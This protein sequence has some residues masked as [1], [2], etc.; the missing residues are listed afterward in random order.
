MSDV[1]SRRRR[2]TSTS[3]TIDTSNSSLLDE[4]WAHT[5]FGPTGIL[6]EVF[7]VIDKKPSGTHADIAAPGEQLQGGE[8]EIKRDKQGGNHTMTQIE[9]PGDVHGTLSY[10]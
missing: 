1:Q 8:G 2:P 10:E 5:L 6:T 4:K 9:G 3:S 7:D